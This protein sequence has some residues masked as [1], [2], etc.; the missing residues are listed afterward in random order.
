MSPDFGGAITIGF[1]EQERGEHTWSSGEG[2]LRLS[3]G[4]VARVRYIPKKHGE[5]IILQYHLPFY[6]DKDKR[7]RIKAMQDNWESVKNGLPPYE[8]EIG[9][10]LEILPGYDFRKPLSLS[11]SV[12]V[13][14]Q[15]VYE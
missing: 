3:G 10:T 14:V 2:I 7:V 15:I 8:I 13:T 1:G 6:L 12:P 11:G 4:H 9:A 5:I